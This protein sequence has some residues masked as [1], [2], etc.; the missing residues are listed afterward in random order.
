MCA[1]GAH[2]QLL[3][4]PMMVLKYHVQKLMHVAIPSSGSIRGPLGWYL[5]YLLGDLCIYQSISWFF[6][7]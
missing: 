2:F 1:I 7:I 4:M 6:G 3:I 5:S